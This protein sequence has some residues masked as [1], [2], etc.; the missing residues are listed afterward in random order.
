LSFNAGYNRISGYDFPIR[1][2]DQQG[3]GDLIA[4]NYRLIY[5]HLLKRSKRDIYSRFGQV[6]ISQLEHTPFGGDYNGRMFSAETRL[7]FPGM[8]RHHSMNFRLGYLNQD[9]NVEKGSYR[10]ST[11]LF[12]P[13]GYGYVP[14]EDLWVG[15]MNYSLP[16]FY[17]DL[18]IGSLAYIQRITTNLFYDQGNGL[19]NGESF[20]F[21]SVGFEMNFD[22]NLMRFLTPFNMGF[23]FYYRLEDGGYNFQFLIG[24]FGF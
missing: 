22:F 11:I 13:R 21:N 17:P 24:E 3:D 5:Y 9:L 6:F 15:S 20:L 7:Y 10:F 2:L 16:L 1:Y 23:R 8:V 14:Y 19:R 4:N 18:A 12:Y